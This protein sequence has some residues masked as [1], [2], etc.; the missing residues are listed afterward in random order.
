MGRYTSLLDG[1]EIVKISENE[2]GY[3]Y[4]GFSRWG[5]NEWLIMRKKTDNTEFLFAIGKGSFEN[6]WDVRSEKNYKKPSE[7]TVSP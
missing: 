7:F 4:Y 5:R 2:S 3:D 6:A 1:M